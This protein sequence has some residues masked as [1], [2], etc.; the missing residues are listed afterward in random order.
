M[1]TAKIRGNM[2]QK[3]GGS[4]TLTDRVRGWVR[5][6]ADPIADLLARLGFTPNTLTLIGFLMNVAVAVVLS[7]GRLRWGA[8]AFFL[9]SAFD[10]LDGALDHLHGPNAP[11]QDYG[12]IKKEFYFLG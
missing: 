10:G 4:L 12:N 3:M 1:P 6:V 8:L 7:Q 2:G 11:S 9:A 5:G